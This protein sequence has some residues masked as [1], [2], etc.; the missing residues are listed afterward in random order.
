MRIMAVIG[1]DEGL[2]DEAPDEATL[3]DR[4]LL[5]SSASN[6]FWSAATKASSSS[7]HEIE[8]RLI[9]RKLFGKMLD[10]GRVLE[11]MR[12]VLSV[13]SQ[14]A[15]IHYVGMADFEYAVTPGAPSSSCIAPVPVLLPDDARPVPLSIIL[16]LASLSRAESI[17][18]SLDLHSRSPSL[19][20]LVR[21]AARDRLAPNCTLIVAE[22]NGHRCELTE[23]V[24]LLVEAEPDVIDGGSLA[25]R[26]AEVVGNAALV[27]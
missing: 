2:D 10:P 23:D 18:I 3:A 13:K 6:K 15:W 21:A 5:Q 8:C 16:S 7:E 17:V 27:L 25:K 9:N 26:L 22:S 11:E 14:L 4:H 12:E 19:I 1:A 24:V 20:D